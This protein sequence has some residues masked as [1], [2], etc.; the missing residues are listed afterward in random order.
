MAL[1]KGRDGAI[2]G[3]RASVYDLAL[4]LSADRR[5]NVLVSTCAGGVIDGLG[6]CVVPGERESAADAVG[7]VDIAGMANAIAVG[8]EPLVETG[9]AEVGTAQGA[10]LN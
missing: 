2:V 3:A 1:V 5:Q 6:I 4:D 7:D 8:V 9:I 10:V